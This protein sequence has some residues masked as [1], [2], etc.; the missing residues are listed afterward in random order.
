MLVLSRKEKETIL[1]GDNIEITICRVS[2][3]RVTIGL[4]APSDLSI[5]RGEIGEYDAAGAI[6]PPEPMEKPSAAWTGHQR[7]LASRLARLRRRAAGVP[8][9]ITIE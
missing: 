7:G 3:R 9:E 6:E 4:R 5:R 2:G 1:V 8:Q